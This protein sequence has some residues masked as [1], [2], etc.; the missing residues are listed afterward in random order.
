[1]SSQPENIPL[2]P[3]ED[4]FSDDRAQEAPLW[5]SASAEAW[6][7]ASAVGAEDGPEAPAPP[8]E[9][10]L[11]AAWE[12]PEIRLPARVPHFGHLLMFLAALTFV[13]G[14]CMYVVT[15][16][17]IRFRLFGVTSLTGAT[18]DIHYMLGSEGVLYLCTFAACLLLFP[19]LWH[20]SFM[21]GIQWSGGTAL[22]LRKRLV[23]AAAFCFVFAIL[24]GLL[25]KE[26][27]NAPIDQVIRERGAAWLLFGFGV[28]LA[29]FF[30]EIAF[31]GFLLP[32]CCTAWDWV[33]E[34]MTGRPPRPLATDGHPQ[35]SLGAMIVGSILT[36]VPFALMHAEQI[37]GAVGPLLLLVCVSLVLCAVRLATR[38]VA[39]SVLVHACYNFLLFS[40]MLLGTSGFRHMEKM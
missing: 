19:L 37:A 7:H 14:T 10:A 26:P 24:N 32:A 4:D 13:G 27:V 18:K 16:T 39:A 3:Q 38:S 6:P 2:N 5:G 31:R 11:F 33:M 22:R 20:E 40:L 17:A 28:T 8:A 36:S 23:L 35:W 15:R 12:Q 34:R 29:P 1:M 30:E 21:A 9:P 25:I